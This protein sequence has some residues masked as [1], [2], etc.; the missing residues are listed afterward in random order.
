MENQTKT[1]VETEMGTRVSIGA[2]VR[3]E[4]ILAFGALRRTVQVICQYRLLILGVWVPQAFVPKPHT[5]Q[6]V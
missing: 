1:K 5:L 6:K 3:H 2:H 4:R